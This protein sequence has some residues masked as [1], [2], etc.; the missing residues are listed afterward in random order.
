MS[1]RATLRR[2]AQGSVLIIVLW[3]AFG[4]VSLAL[5][6]GHSMMFELRASDNRV[7]SQSAEQIIDGAAR[8]LTYILT[9]QI[10]NGSN[11]QILDLSAYARDAAPVGDGH[12][13]IIG[14]DTNTTTGPGFLSF[15]LVDEASKLN[16]NTLISNQVIW[17][18]R[19]TTDFT[20]GILDWRDTNGNG[21]TTMFYSM[22]QPSYLCKNDP[23]ETVDELRMVYGAD[24]DT[25]IGEDFNRNGVLDPNET[26]ENQ[27]NMLDPGLLEYVTVYSREPNP[28]GINISNMS[29]SETALRSLL[30][31]NFTTARADEI[32]VNLGFTSSSGTAGRGPGT[33]GTTGRGGA[34]GPAVTVV[35]PPLASPLAFYVKSK[36]T[37]TEF[38]QVA[39]NFTTT[40]NSV[41]TGRV[42]VNTA[43]LAVLTCLLGGDSSA[44]QQLIN[45]RLSNANN[46]PSIAWVT[47]AL[48]TS[49]PDALTAIAGGDYITTQTYQYSADIAA[50]GPHGRGYRRVKFIFDT[51]TGT[52]EIV[53]RQDLTHLGWALGVDIRQRWVL[54]KATK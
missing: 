52:P 3:I 15:G 39:T 6:F 25:L 12:F 18:P 21:P 50:L 44:A 30:S 37:S 47:D 54:A 43:S 23:F 11:G 36:M 34:G 40:T 5:Y 9:T 31:T 10:S 4:L 22:E 29:S 49:Y 45:Y 41:I 38:A 27:N 19:M 48:G 24:M 28:G 14:R 17:L 13:W 20:M 35:V 42:N 1:P 32:M 7:A 53:H 8:Y 2:R 16:L 33:T 26:D 51:S 46:L